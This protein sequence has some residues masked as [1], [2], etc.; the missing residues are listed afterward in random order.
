MRYQ[1][2]L[3]PDSDVDAFRLHVAPLATASFTSAPKAE[4]LRR[5]HLALSGLGLKPDARTAGGF[6]YDALEAEGDSQLRL[7]SLAT[8]TLPGIFLHRRARHAHEL[9]RG[10]FGVVGWLLESATG[11]PWLVPA[12]T[13]TRSAEFM[14]SHFRRFSWLDAR[15]LRELREVTPLHGL[16]SAARTVADAPQW[17]Q[18]VD[19]YVEQCVADSRE[20]LGQASAGAREGLAAITSVDNT[21]WDFE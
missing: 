18:R 3:L 11:C 7:V 9:T 2:S 21:D 17:G 14:S 8:T 1:L 20:I 19:A 5:I 13:A 12:Q 4:R 15:E 16:R 10:S 6:L